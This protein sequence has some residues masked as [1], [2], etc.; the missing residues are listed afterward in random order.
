MH[1]LAT[2]GWSPCSIFLLRMVEVECFLSCPTRDRQAY[3]D[4]RHDHNTHHEMT[5]TTK[6]V[7]ATAFAPA[8]VQ[9]VSRPGRL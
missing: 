6:W 5:V 3:R 9:S 7:T 4:G 2:N 1:P 8:A